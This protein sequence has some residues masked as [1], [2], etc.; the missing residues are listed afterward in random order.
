[1]SGSRTSGATSQSDTPANGNP[2]FDTHQY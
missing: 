2:D 1:V